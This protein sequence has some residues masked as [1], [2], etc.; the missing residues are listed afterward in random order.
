MADQSVSHVHWRLIV[1]ELKFKVLDYKKLSDSK[2][3]E[4]WMKISKQ[5]P[6]ISEA[7]SE[8][9]YSATVE[10]TP[11]FL[12]YIASTSHEH[13]SCKP[14]NCFHF[15][16]NWRAHG[17]SWMCKHHLD[18]ITKQVS[19]W[20]YQIDTIKLIVSTNRRSFSLEGSV[21]HNHVHKIILSIWIVCS[22]SNGTHQMVP[23]KWWS[24]KWMSTGSSSL[25]NSFFIFHLIKSAF[26]KKLRVSL[27]NFKFQRQIPR[28]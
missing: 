11:D 19:S 23:I 7:D 27:N 5:N 16:G 17:S 24:S 12:K 1:C 3:E 14:E 2:S 4:L 13:T 26:E 15:N 28:V 10:P 8:S 18:L 21:L 22:P 9:H 20:N 25:A 6:S